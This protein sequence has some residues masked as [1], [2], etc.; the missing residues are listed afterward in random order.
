[1]FDKAAQYYCHVPGFK[2]DPFLGDLTDE[3]LED[4]EVVLELPILDRGFEPPRT[5]DPLGDT[6]DLVVFDLVR[7]FD[8]LL[9]RRFRLISRYTPSV[10]TNARTT[11]TIRMMIINQG[12]LVSEV[13]LLGLSKL[14]DGEPAAAFS[15]DP[16][17]SPEL[18][19]KLVVLSTSCSSC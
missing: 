6:L 16:P 7:F 9:P 19:S 11:V 10:A 1:M 18:P 5:F 12:E 13:D 8:V 2:I 17:P 15:V 4:C 3:S 14:P